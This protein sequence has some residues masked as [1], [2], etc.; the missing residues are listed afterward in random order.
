VSLIAKVWG[1]AAPANS[2]P[3]PTEYAEALAGKAGLP[4]RYL[5]AE[6]AVRILHR[7]GAS[8]DPEVGFIR[9]HREVWLI[10]LD[11]VNGAIHG[12]IMRGVRTK[13]FFSELLSPVVLGGFWNFQG[14]TFGKP[15]VLVE[16]IKDVLAV[17]RFYPYALAVLS[18]RPT[19]NAITLL[20]KLT[21][22]L[23]VIRDNDTAGADLVRKLRK[24]GLGFQI[25]DLVPPAGDP[26]DLFSPHTRGATE[27]FLRMATSIL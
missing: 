12:W 20:S 27:G 24:S 22:R 6:T 14:F 1:A 21:T 18:A 7:V 26:G 16:G 2:C 5:P 15:I 11:D 23:V 13:G 3:R 9:D 8:H 19:T 10:P 4:A 25:M 17:Q